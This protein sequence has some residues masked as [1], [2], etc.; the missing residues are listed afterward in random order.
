MMRLQG[1]V[2]RLTIHLAEGDRH[3][4]QAL[5]AVVLERAHAA[6]LAGATLLR[7]LAGFGEGG[8]VHT[9]HVLSL[10]DDLPLVV[11]VVDSADRIHAFLPHLEFLP[12]ALVTVE[13][14]EAV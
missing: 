14:V 1:P 7:G 3:D 2:Q 12:L 13:D 11:V 9:A 10:S 8:T 5:S 4:G 6:G